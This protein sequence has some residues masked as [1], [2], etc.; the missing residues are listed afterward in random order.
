MPRAY[1]ADARATCRW[2]YD[3]MLIW[4]AERVTRYAS[5]IRYACF[6]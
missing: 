5:Y 1:A 6:I 3:M 2:L 4:R